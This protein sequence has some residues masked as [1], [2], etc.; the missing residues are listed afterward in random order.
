MVVS[1]GSSSKFSST[2]AANLAWR[3]GWQMARFQ[4]LV[5]F[6]R[7]TET[8]LPLLLTVLINWLLTSLARF[9]VE[10]LFDFD[11]IGKG[12]SG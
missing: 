6:A 11:T 9:I 10:E 1:G 7:S 5:S 12:S 4:E 2:T 8:V 3:S